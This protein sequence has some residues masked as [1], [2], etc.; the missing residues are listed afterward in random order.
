MPPS[1]HK[2]QLLDLELIYKDALLARGMVGGDSDSVVLRP[3]PVVRTS[4]FESSC[5]EC[6]A[7]DNPL[8]LDTK[9]SQ[10]VC[11]LCGFVDPNPIHCE[12]D[13]LSRSMQLGGRYMRRKTVP[14]N[15][16][17]YFSEK[18]RCANGEGMD[19]RPEGCFKEGRPGGMPP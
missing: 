4:L 17:Y 9:N 11:R 1:T 10:L 16:T 7:T 12:W 13:N 8:V 6:G 14:Y 15:H 3:D 18:M 2:P 19:A 5:Q